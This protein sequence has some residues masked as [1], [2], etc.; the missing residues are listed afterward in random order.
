MPR[1]TQEF[2]CAKSGGGCGG[3]ILAKLN[4]AINGI[5]EVVCPKCGH[6]HQR[7]I[8]DGIIIE[9]GR[10]LGVHSENPKQEIMPTMGS[11]SKKPFTQEMKDRAGGPNER[12]AVVIS[13]GKGNFLGGRGMWAQRFGGNL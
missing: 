11:Y 1:I 5:V 6:K 2:Y 9:E 12:D 3:Y 13:D 4:D 8:K 10:Y 7:N